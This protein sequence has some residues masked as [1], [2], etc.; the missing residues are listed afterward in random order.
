MQS[1]YAGTFIADAIQHSEM[2][3]KELAEA[4]HQSAQAISGYSTGRRPIPFDKAVDLARQLKNG[5]FNVALAAT[6]FG[7]LAP[8]KTNNLSSDNVFLLRDLKNYEED[9]RKKI[10]DETFKIL[11]L[12]EEDRTY[13]QRL[14]LETFAKEMSEELSAELTCFIEFCKEAGIQSVSIFDELNE[15]N[16]RE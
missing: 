5:K 12:K 13:Q 10:E 1:R 16:M 6:F 3:L 14:F 4:T 11:M 2:K 7:T 9:D 8:R 15:E